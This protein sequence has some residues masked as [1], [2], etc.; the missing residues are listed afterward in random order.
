MRFCLDI[1]TLATPEQSGY[2]IVIPNYAI[3]KIPEVL[4]SELEWMYV[5]LPIQEQLDLGLKTDAPT[6]NFWFNICAQEF[7]LALCEMQKSFTLKNSKVIIN[8]ED[9]DSHNIPLMLRNFLHGS[10]KIDNKVKVFGNGCHFDC[11]IL[12]EN[13]R[14]LFGEGNLWH[15]SAPN[16]IR[17]LRLLLSEQEE[18]DMKEAVEPVLE[19][20]CQAMDEQGYT[21]D[22][23]LH[24]P[25]FDAAKEALFATYILNLKKST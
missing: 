20:F 7:P 24:N 23:C 12:Q 25:I 19:Q 17:T 21:Y 1:E 5:Q 15:Y 13:H 18:Q 4:T 11:S 9:V 2:G 3:V 6:M 16:N 22:L 8:G 14:V 10:D